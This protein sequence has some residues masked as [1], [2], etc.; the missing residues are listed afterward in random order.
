MVRSP[1]DAHVGTNKIVADVVPLY[2][3]CRLHVT[4]KRLGTT[5]RIATQNTDHWHRRLRTP[6][7]RPRCSAAEQR[8]ELAAH[9]S[10][11]SSARARSVGGTSIPSA[12][13][14]V[15]L[16]TKSNLVGCST[17]RSPGFA[18]CRTLST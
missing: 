11:T 14:V 1:C 8:D 6:R 13:A 9:H 10:I 2:A 18:P 4:S 7:T 5:P 3:T 16:M 15:R 12:L 17:G